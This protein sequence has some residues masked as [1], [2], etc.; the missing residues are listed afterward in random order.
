LQSSRFRAIETV[1]PLSR[2]TGYAI[3]PRKFKRIKMLDVSWLI[4]A[5]RQMA[6]PFAA[7][8]GISNWRQADCAPRPAAMDAIQRCGCVGYNARLFRLVLNLVMEAESLN[9]IQAKLADL[10][11]R[12]TQL[13]GFL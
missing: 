11:D 5:R 6:V 7:R 1:H 10:G 4:A 12:A 8:H 2:Q 13:R 3:S 9:Q